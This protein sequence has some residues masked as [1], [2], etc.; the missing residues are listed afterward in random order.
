M[1]ILGSFSEAF[2][3][4]YCSYR[5]RNYIISTEIKKYID[6]NFGHIVQQLILDGLSLSTY[7]ANLFFFVVELFL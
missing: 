6:I 1:S 2:F 3:K 7:S 4:I 5:Y